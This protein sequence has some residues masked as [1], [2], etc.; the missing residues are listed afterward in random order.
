LGIGFGGLDWKIEVRP[1]MEK[2]LKMLTIPVYIHLS[3]EESEFVP[4]SIRS[5]VYKLPVDGGVI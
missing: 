1:Q 5:S 3:A 2:Y 4:V